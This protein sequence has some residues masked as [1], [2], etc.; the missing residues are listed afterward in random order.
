MIQIRLIW[1]CPEAAEIAG[2]A[3]LK[4]LDVF[5]VTH[6][7]TTVRKFL[8]VLNCNCLLGEKTGVR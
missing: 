5:I 4:F 3:G 1:K 8:L 2:F 7:K 6:M